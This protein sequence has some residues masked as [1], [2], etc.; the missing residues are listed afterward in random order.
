MFHRLDEQKRCLNLIHQ[1]TNKNEE[2]QST[3]S[4]NICLTTKTEISERWNRRWRKTFSRRFELTRY[5]AQTTNT[6]VLFFQ[7]NTK[8]R[9]NIGKTFEKRQKHFEMAKKPNVEKKFSLRFWTVERNIIGM[10]KCRCPKL[11]H[12]KILFFSN[13]TNRIFDV[14]FFLRKFAV[15]T[16]RNLKI[17][18]KFIDPLTKNVFRC[19]TINKK[20]TTQM[21]F[22][23]FLIVS[24]YLPLLFNDIWRFSI[25]SMRNFKR[26]RSVLTKSPW[27]VFAVI[28]RGS[29]QK[30]WLTKSWFP[31]A[32]AKTWREN[33]IRQQTKRVFDNFLPH[34]RVN[35]DYFERKR[36]PNVSWRKFKKKNSEKT[37]KNRLFIVKNST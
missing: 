17:I 11:F 8:M 19:F 15:E 18:L 30:K 23:D 24:S 21:I 16:D 14:R 22:I 32:Q 36:T 13:L 12:L 3:I 35:E 10:I 34:C 4:S 5:V 28:C 9:K 26:N 6:N 31:C 27:N 20:W 1:L 29:K 37:L 33:R 2:N 25:V 7:S